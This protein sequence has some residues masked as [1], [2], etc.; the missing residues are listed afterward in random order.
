MRVWGKIQQNEWMIGCISHHFTFLGRSS[1][2][3]TRML[4]QGE[5]RVGIKTNWGF[6]LSSKWVACRW[7]KPPLQHEETI[8]NGN[9]TW[10]R[11]VKLQQNEQIRG[12]ISY[13]FTLLGRAIHPLASALMQRVD[14]VSAKQFLCF[15]PSLILAT[16]RGGHIPQVN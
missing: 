7:G 9:T 15:H 3:L 5:E 10:E 6:H 2:Q 16:W 12:G 13:E 1:P 8:K 14:K 11:G 4:V